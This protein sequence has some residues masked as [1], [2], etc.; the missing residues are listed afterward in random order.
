MTSMAGDIHAIE[1]WAAVFKHPVELTKDVSSH[2]L[3]HRRGI[4]KDI[5]T[6]KTD[7]ANGKYFNA[8]ATTADI[9]ELLLGPVNPKPSSIMEANNLGFTVLEIPDFIAGFLYG[10]TGDNNLTELEACWTSDLPIVQ[11]LQ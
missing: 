9:L 8:G 10:W 1:S 7:F 11:D 2:Y 5:D 6:E 4:D 3:L